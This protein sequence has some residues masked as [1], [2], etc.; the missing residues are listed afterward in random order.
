MS[1]WDNHILLSGMLFVPSCPSPEL[2][3][4]DLASGPYQGF[5]SN[6]KMALLASA[7]S[8]SPKMVS[9][10]LLLFFN[11]LLPSWRRSCGST[12]CSL[13][14]FLCVLGLLTE[15]L[16]LLVVKLGSGAQDSFFEEM[17]L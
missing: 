14:P 5:L 12:A 10:H 4:D 9:L 2:P 15:L 7:S 13:A 17:S 16:S 3:D 8:C 1:K 6:A 11:T